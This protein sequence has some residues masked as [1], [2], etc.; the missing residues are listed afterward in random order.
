MQRKF[1][2]KMLR[3]VSAASLAVLLAGSAYAAFKNMAIV[4]AANSKLSDVPMADLVKYC[5]GT[6]KT[7]PDGKNFTIV[8]KSPD[9][10]E[11]NGV[12]QKLFGGTPTEAKA[13]I[14]KLN[15]SRTVV[16]IASS[17]EDV[18]KTVEATP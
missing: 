17:D 2:V 5:K 10:P 18:L 11:M 1:F 6:S 16:K 4:T 12:L 7:W 8:I 13:A 9:A 15:E 14:Y 3:I